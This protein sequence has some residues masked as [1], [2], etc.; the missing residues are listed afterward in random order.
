MLK[1][2]RTSLLPAVTFIALATGHLMSTSAMAATIRVSQES[3]PGLGDFDDHVLGSIEAFSSS[4]TINETYNYRNASFNGPLDLTSNVSHLFLVEATDGLGLF[5][6][7]DRPRDG[8]GGNAQMQFDLQGDIASI[9]SFDDPGELY[10]SD[11]TRFTAQNRWI[12]CCTDGFAIGTLESDWTMFA[13]FTSLPI[14]LSSWQAFSASDTESIGLVIDPGR[15]VRL[16]RFPEVV[17]VPEP[18]AAIGLIAL[19]LLGTGLR[20][21]PKQSNILG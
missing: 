18:S 20:L 10:T 16:D 9:I 21:F 5:S 17:D 4:N 2:I 15:R 8:S 3:A 6:V 14:G 13:Q 11:D 7:H 1:K 19:G 12:P